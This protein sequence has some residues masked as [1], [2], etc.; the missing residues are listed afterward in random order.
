M[1]WRQ[2]QINEEKKKNV[3]KIDFFILYMFDYIIK[4]IIK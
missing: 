1:K 3:N 4:K 2:E